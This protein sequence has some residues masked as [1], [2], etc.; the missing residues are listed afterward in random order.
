[1]TLSP[2]KAGGLRG[3]GVWARARKLFEDVYQAKHD[4]E[5]GPQ[6][7][8]SKHGPT[9]EWINRLAVAVITDRMVL[10]VFGAKLAKETPRL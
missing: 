1:M 9:V 3:T 5:P 10:S 4:K 7:K 8:H 6:P 2:H